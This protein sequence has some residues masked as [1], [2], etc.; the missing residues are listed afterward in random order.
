MRHIGD[1]KTTKFLRGIILCIELIVGTT[2]FEEGSKCY[3]RV[4]SVLRYV[5]VSVY[6]HRVFR[7]IVKRR[8]VKASSRTVCQQ[9]SSESSSSAAVT[10]GRIR[11]SFRN[12]PNFP[13]LYFSLSLPFNKGLCSFK[14]C[15]FISRCASER[16]CVSRTKAIFRGIGPANVTFWGLVRDSLDDARCEKEYCVV[17]FVRQRAE[18]LASCPWY[19]LRGSPDLKLHF[20]QRPA[21]RLQSIR[22]MFCKR[23]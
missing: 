16:R 17:K 22:R 8:V 5:P 4:T 11:F 13:I 21:E 20:E 14:P 2:I 1:C 9:L 7:E 10:S 18:L 6:D 3:V 12:P 15:V 19:F 23:H